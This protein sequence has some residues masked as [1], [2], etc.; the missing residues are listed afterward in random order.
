MK[1]IT[2]LLIILTQTIIQ[3]AAQDTSNKGTI[4]L[5]HQGKEIAFAYNEMVK[6]I[7][8]AVDGD[9]IYLSTGYFQGNFIINKKLAFVGSG[10]D[11]NKGWDNCTCYEGDISIN[12]PE[13]TKY[14]V[15]LFDR[16]YFYKS[17]VSFNSYI[18]N[19]TFRKCKWDNTHYGSFLRFYTD[20]EYILIDRCYCSAWVYE[21]QHIKKIVARNSILGGAPNV[22]KNA[23]I[24]ARF[25]NCNINCYNNST[26]DIG[27]NK[28]S[29]CFYGTFYNCILD[30]QGNYITN[31]N[32]SEAATILNNC[33]Y[34]IGKVPLD[35]GCTLKDC[36]KYSSNQSVLTLTKEELEKNKYLG[37]DG[38]IV[39]CYGG[40]NPYTLDYS[41]PTIKNQ[42]HLDKNKKQIQFNIKITEQQ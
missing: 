20:V 6:A 11:D 33:L 2:I 16:I 36:Y 27:N 41:A 31:P 4:T 25:Y 24:R 10:A 26:E 8:A 38:T 23:E 39:G 17:S 18:D 34:G 42:V 15:R 21:A 14:D 29:V 3:M 35:Q 5:S 28:R 32:N 22:G 12:L 40:K 30:P 19:V 1:R 37:N 9:T 7:D 13:N